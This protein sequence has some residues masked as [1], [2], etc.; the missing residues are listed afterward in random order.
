MKQILS[1]SDFVPIATVNSLKLELK[2]RYRLRRKEQK[3][4][5]Q[6]LAKRS[7]VSHR[8]IRR[9]ESSGEI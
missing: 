4:F 6:I 7:G 2:G 5:Q 9:F 3:I 8:S 1:I